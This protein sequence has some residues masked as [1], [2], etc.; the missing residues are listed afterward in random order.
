M[1]A[2]DVAGFVIFPCWTLR[3]RQ[4]IWGQPVESTLMLAGSG[5]QPK[6]EGGQTQLG[7]ESS[8]LTVRKNICNWFGFPY[9]NSLIG[10]GVMRKCYTEFHFTD[11][12]IF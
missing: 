9:A 4:W 1:A 11:I 8:G 2:Q 12:E 7:L 6:Q 5:Q 3:A 10:M